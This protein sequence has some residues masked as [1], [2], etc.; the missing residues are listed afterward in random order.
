MMRLK[1]QEPA[2]EAVAHSTAAAHSTAVHS[3]TA[4]AAAAAAVEVEEEEVEAVPA[5]HDHD[6]DRARDRADDSSPVSRLVRLGRLGR[7]HPYRQHNRRVGGGG[8][9]CAFTPYAP[10]HLVTS[11]PNEA[12]FK[13][14]YF[15]IKLNLFFFYSF[16]YKKNKNHIIYS[17]LI[18]EEVKV[19]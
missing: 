14:N 8:Y 9:N 18:F 6:H 3:R 13:K 10:R 11:S 12:F 2:A 1:V 7:T 16:F 15:F 5:L 19:V 4:A 17:R